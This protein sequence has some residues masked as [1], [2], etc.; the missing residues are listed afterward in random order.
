MPAKLDKKKLIRQKHYPTPPP[1]E[2]SLLDPETF[3]RC[4]GP[5]TEDLGFAIDLVLKINFLQAPPPPPVGCRIQPVVMCHCSFCTKTNKAK[6][7]RPGLISVKD[8]R[9]C[10][11]LAGYFHP[12][13]IVR[14]SGRPGQIYA[15]SPDCP[16]SGSRQRAQC[17]G[18]TT[19]QGLAQ[20]HLARAFLSPKPG[21]P[22]YSWAHS[23]LNARA[24]VQPKAIVEPC[25]ASCPQ[26]PS[27]AAVLSL[28]EPQLTTRLHKAK[29]V[30]TGVVYML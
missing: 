4:L 17:L 29:R 10:V 11:S 20:H 24:K 25:S 5:D 2:P 6:M 15:Q 9:G 13:K 27:S 26:K 14:A 21:Q 18:P 28:T 12:S 1:D 19:S 22:G 8:K 7:T 30:H 16:L 3:W 23:S